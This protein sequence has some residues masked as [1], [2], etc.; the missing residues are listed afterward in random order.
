M[1]RISQATAAFVQLDQIDDDQAPALD[2][3]LRH[4]TQRQGIAPS[5]REG[6]ADLYGIE[7][8]VVMRLAHMLESFGITR[9]IIADFIRFL[10]SSDSLP[11]RWHE[12]DGHK[13][14]LTR[15]EEALERAR[16]GQDFAIG[17]CLRNGTIQPRVWIPGEAESEAV[18]ALKVAGRKAAPPPADDAVLRLDAGR[19]IRELVATLEG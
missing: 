1:Y 2:K 5:D 12:G 19:L 10:Q 16:E 3:S 4:L 9:H 7:A 11:N 15:V 8:V 17:L 6:R 18:K 14:A 13:V